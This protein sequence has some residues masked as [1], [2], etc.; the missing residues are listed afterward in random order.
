MTETYDLH[1]EV[2]RLQK[3]V[4][5]YIGVES[6]SLIFDFK[7]IEGNIRLN[8][9]TVNPQHR[10]SFLF[11]SVEGHDKVEALTK[12]L[13]YVKNY[14]ERESSYTIQ[15]SLKDDNSLQTSYFSAK[16]IFQALEKFYFGRDANSTIIFSVV[17]NPIT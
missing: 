9:I 1:L 6:N 14:K 8:I 12:A 10:Q 3:E 5:S 16:N 2:A 11:H 4:E 7:E 13:D 15:W 17:L